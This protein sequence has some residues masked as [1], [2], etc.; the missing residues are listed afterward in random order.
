MMQIMFQVTDLITLPSTV[1][2]ECDW[3]EFIWIFIPL[4]QISGLTESVRIVPSTH[5]E[6]LLAFWCTTIVFVLCTKMP[7]IMHT[8]DNFC[9]KSIFIYNKGSI[10][11]N[12]ILLSS[13]NITVLVIILIFRH[14]TFHFRIPMACWKQVC[15]FQSHTYSERGAL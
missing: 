7:H 1:H 14:T 15:Y 13:F 4:W 3:M 6:E 11:R 9:I 10:L 5:T 8:C 12:V 2:C